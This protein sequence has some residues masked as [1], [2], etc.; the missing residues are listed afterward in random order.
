MKPSNILSLILCATTLFGMFYTNTILKREFLEIDLDDQ[1]K[2]YISH[3][4]GDYSVLDIRGSNG[5]A[6]EIKESKKNDIKVLRSRL[7]HFKQ[8]LIED[9]LFIEFT[10]SNISIE[11]ALSNDTPAGIIIEKSVLSKIIVT[12]TY[13][14]ITAFRDQNMDIVL[15]ESSIS[16][17]ADC[18]LKSLNIYAEDNSQYVFSENNSIDSVHLYMMDN[19]IGRLNEIEYLNLNHTLED[20]VT[21]ILSKNSFDRI[22]G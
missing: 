22:Q 5:Y 11:Q 15:K 12:N 19:S 21:L 1:Y 16:E 17:I 6:I 2:N 3:D 18:K 13:N 20:S 14:R 4:S 8:K 9:T 10:G 7:K